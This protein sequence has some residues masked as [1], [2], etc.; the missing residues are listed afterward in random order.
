MTLEEIDVE[1]TYIGGE[2]GV[3]FG[4]KIYDV[5]SYDLSADD[6]MNEAERTPLFSASSETIT[7]KWWDLYQAKL[8]AHLLAASASALA[9]L[10][11]LF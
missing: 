11:V 10:Y 7:L 4:Y 9:V 8:Q 1:T 5:D 6:L 2:Y 3:V